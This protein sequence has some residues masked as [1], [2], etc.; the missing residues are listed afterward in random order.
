MRERGSGLFHEAHVARGEVD[1]VRE[2]LIQLRGID[3]KP[4]S[5]RPAVL[6]DGHRRQPKA[7]I[8]DV[9]RTLDCQVREGSVHPPAVDASTHN[10]VMAAPGVV[11]A[12]VAVRPESTIEVRFGKGGD[13]VF[14]A[15]LDGGIVEG[16]HGAVQRSQQ[17]L[18]RSQQPVVIVKATLGD[19]ENLPA[20]AQ[21]LSRAHDA[22][23]L[24][25]LI[26]K[27][28]AG[29]DGGES[30]GAGKYAVEH[31]TDLDAIV[32]GP[33]RSLHQG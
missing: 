6:I 11:R 2:D 13:V 26:S 19:E 9:V 16:R 15:Q 33:V 24:L 20:Y 30:A 31:L 8:A 12:G 10:D 32:N 22:C 25:E 7:A 3:A 5:Q 29:E 14:Q 28:A 4:R 21:S 17:P 27:T 1:Q 18:L 23:H